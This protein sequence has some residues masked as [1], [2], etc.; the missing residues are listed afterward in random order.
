M[1]NAPPVNYPVGRSSL[2]L[3]VLLGT[4]LATLALLAAWSALVPAHPWR[5]A[6]STVLLGASGVWVLRS[7]RRRFRGALSWDGGAWWLEGGGHASRV[8]PD[9]VLD[10]QRVMLVRTLSSMPRR[11]CW[12]WIDSKG[13][14]GA[15]LALRRALYSRARPDALQPSADTAANP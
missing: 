10:L 3:W 13:D 9:V 15:W 5:Q 6:A 1:R 12:F 8:Q 7:E 14:P 11:T 2:G 4:W